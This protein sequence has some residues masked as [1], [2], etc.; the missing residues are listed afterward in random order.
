MTVYAD[1]IPTIN[2]YKDGQ[3]LISNNQI[4]FLPSGD[5]FT[6]HRILI[7]NINDTGLYE[8]RVQNSFGSISYSKHINIEGQKPFIQ[9]ISNQTIISGKQFT[10]ACYASGQPN[11]HL[12]WIDDT[13]KQIINTSLTSPILLTSISTQSNSYT[14][15]AKN[16]HGDDFKQV[17][18]KIQI[19]SK[20][21][22]FTP[23]KVI[24]MNQTI[25][26]FC[27]AEGDNDFELN[28]LTPSAKKFNT[29]EIVSNNNQK[30]LSLTIENVQMSD[31]GVYECYTRNSYSEDRSKFEIIVQNVPDKIENIFIENSNLIT[32]VKPF[33][34]NSKI[35][36]YILH[37]K[38]RQ[39]NFLYLLSFS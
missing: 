28:L 22:S 11:L 34:G 38:Y 7:S 35:L 13:T 25:N 1:P 3:Q 6:W 5:I 19:P 21:L 36:Q 39:G 15:Q 30:T 16:S 23:N 33:D 4:E 31:S 10:L 12:K 20:I 27:L 18:V 37:I 26:I 2:L 9:T 8:Y 32:W 17:Y 14:C 29:V 24:R